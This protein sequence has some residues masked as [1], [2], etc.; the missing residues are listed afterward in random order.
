MKKHIPIAGKL[1]K[2]TLLIFAVLNIFELQV[3][4][5]K[6]TKVYHI[7]IEEAI[8]FAKSQ[9]KTVRAA[10]M[11]IS[12][13]EKD[14][15]DAYSAALPSISINGSYQRFSD[16][17]L[18]IEGLSNASTGPRKP[19]PNA[20]A[21]GFE[22]LFNI[23]GG[24]RQMAL[25]QEQALRLSLTKINAAEAAGNVAVQ[26]SSSY[27]N[28]LRLKDLSILISEQVTRAKTRLKNIN[29]LY[30]NQKVTK[31]DVLRA[32]VSLANAALSLEQNN[33]DMFIENQRL[34]VL[35]D[36][37][38]SIIIAPSDSSSI[39]KPDPETLL[40][41]L[42]EKGE[43]SYSTLKAE[44]NV[45]LQKTRLDM[46]SSADRPSLNFYTAYGMNYP[47]NLFFPPVDQAY[48]I[49]FVGLKAQY[50]ISSLYQNKN[51]KAAAKIRVSELELQT[52]AIVDNN[53]FETR[54]YL[55]KYTEALNRIKVNQHSVEQAMVNYKIM[56]IKYINQLALLT[57]LLDADNL[58]QESR[59]NLVKSQTDALSTY[60]KIRFSSGNL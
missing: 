57:D 5:Q 18:Y 23:Y 45:E 27:L 13:S 34:N 60:Y 48:S 11:S 44:K 6:E 28:L 53:I 30:K 29:S 3:Y 52:Q 42:K 54:S 8:S 47:N 35:M 21:L 16:L 22:A 19:T 59:S 56:N 4:A 2:L 49:G 41:L 46:I 12:S 20:A 55:I 31:S 51:K 43:N 9:N 32:E 15:K 37:P 24:G 17:T 26:T 39:A 33:N 14:L 7:S 58:L 50:N 38:D 10:Q 40:P 36:L 25:E 1:F